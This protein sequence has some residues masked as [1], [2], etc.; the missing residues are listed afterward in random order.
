[1]LRFAVLASIAL[2]P[3][4]RI[5]L[6]DNNTGGGGDGGI[7]AMVSAACTEAK[8]YQDIATIETKIFQTSCI[9]S[10][11]HNGAATLQGKIDLRAGA[12]HDHLVGVAA[13]V[14]TSGGRK[15]VVAGDVNASYLMLMVQ[16]V[17]PADATPPTVAPPTSV[18][19][20]PQNT[21]GQPIC[22]EK[23]D[24]IA[25]WIMAGAPP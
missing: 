2:A 15:L 24:A 1:M 22:Q 5:A 6:D 21:G 12:A 7:D 23:R 17:K 11:C 9:F 3:A 4:C 25:R 14:D 8:G 10:G 13:V 16:S 20:M 19:F 18:G